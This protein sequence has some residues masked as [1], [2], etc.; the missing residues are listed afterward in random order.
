MEEEEQEWEQEEKEEEEEEKECGNETFHKRMV[1]KLYRLEGN[2]NKTR[3][4]AT[5]LNGKDLFR[6]GFSAV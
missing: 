3:A 1:Y 2:T 5:E 4:L 6:H